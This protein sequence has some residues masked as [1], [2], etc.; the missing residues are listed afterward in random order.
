MFDPKWQDVCVMWMVKL[1][2]EKNQF[3]STTK[4]ILEENTNVLCVK[5]HFLLKTTLETMQ[6]LYIFKAKI[7][8]K[9]ATQYSQQ[10]GI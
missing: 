8:A 6:K 10:A 4:C 3:M 7:L 1:S 5:R 9:H 2:M